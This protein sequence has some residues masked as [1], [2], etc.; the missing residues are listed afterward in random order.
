MKKDAETLGVYPQKRKK[1]KSEEVVRNTA[2]LAL[3]LL[4]LQEIT[5]FAKKQK[6]ISQN[7][8]ANLM[9]VID[10]I[11]AKGIDNK[12]LRECITILEKV[13]VS[14]TLPATFAEPESFPSNT[15][16]QKKKER[17]NR[18]I[19]SVYVGKEKRK[20]S[21]Q[22][23]PQHVEKRNEIKKPEIPYDTHTPEKSSGSMEL[24]IPPQNTAGSMA[25]KPQNITNTKGRKHERPSLLAQISQLFQVP[26]KKQQVSQKKKKR[27]Y[28]DKELPTP[29]QKIA[30]KPQ[31]KTRKTLE[32][33]ASKD[34]TLNDWKEYLPSENAKLLNRTN[35]EE[36][37]KELTPAQKKRMI[38]RLTDEEKEKW[39][40]TD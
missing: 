39:G 17:T 2:G 8:H 38:E 1:Q 9:K 26:P 10:D 4:R 25:I 6:V 18:T 23:S 27:K 14:D 31:K 15:K 24:K 35:E 30:P 32:N 20:I 22:S 29:P 16:K 40:I 19:T 3:S 12:E 28:S 33:T 5:A 37:I 7:C 11:Q 34:M 13:T 36:T 21:T